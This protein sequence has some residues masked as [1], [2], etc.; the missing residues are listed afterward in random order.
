MAGAVEAPPQKGLEAPKTDEGPAS[1][2]KRERK[3]GQAALLLRAA[4]WWD[5]HG[6]PR[7]RVVQA[8]VDWASPISLRRADCGLGWD[9]GRQD[10]ES[11]TS[12]AWTTTTTQ[13][14]LCLWPHTLAWTR[15]NVVSSRARMQ[16]GVRGVADLIPRTPPILKTST[17][18][19][20]KHSLVPC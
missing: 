3:T 4:S 5:W 7:R 17:P 16:R 12:K 10:N 15:L 8:E 19:S 20:Q 9:K 1:K 6:G 13:L 11:T 14:W 18:F 2:E